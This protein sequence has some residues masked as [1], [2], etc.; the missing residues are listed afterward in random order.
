MKGIT[1]KKLEKIHKDERGETYE[2]NLRT[3]TNLI[4]GYRKKGSRMGQ[5]YHKGIEESK[6][7]EI[8]ILLKGKLE[9]FAEDMEGNSTKKIIEAP[10]IVIIEPYIYHEFE[11]IEDVIFVEP[12][13]KHDEYKDVWRKK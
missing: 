11:A 8:F 3:T 4:I 13:P 1:I 5:H 2:T 12:K 7:P 9:F 6:N 10:S